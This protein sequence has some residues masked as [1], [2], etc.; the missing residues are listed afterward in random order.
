MK[1]KIITLCLVVA[2]AATAIIG[3]TLAYFTD[4][5]TKDNTFAV[6]SVQIALVEQER[7]G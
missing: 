5:D 4:T 6:G 2:L 3:G 7:D 1:K